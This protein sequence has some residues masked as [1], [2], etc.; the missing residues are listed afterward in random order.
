MNPTFLTI[1]RQ[2]RNGWERYLAG[3]SL[4]F[5]VYLIIAVP[6]II[7]S[8]YIEG[9]SIENTNLILYGNPLRSI[10]FQGLIGVALL[11]GL[12]LAVTLIHRRKF[13]TLFSVDT[14]IDWFRIIKGFILWLGLYGI[15]F[16]VRYLISPSRYSLTFNISEWLPFTLLVL[17][18][19][20]ILSL[21]VCLLYAYMLQ[22]LGLLIRHPLLLS[23]VWGLILGSLAID[24][25]MPIYWIL[26]VAS[27]MFM[28]WIV[29]KDNRIELVI[30]INI[31]VSLISLLFISSS[32]SLI[33]APTIFKVADFSDFL[34]VFVSYV[35]RAGFF[36]FICFGRRRNLS[37]ST[38]DD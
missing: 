14:A 19:V 12:F 25:K 21:A 23:I 13:M 34:P 32:D 16:S 4:V 17:I 11:L 2:G 1:A 38:I 37:E 8:A 35:L 33:K 28:T 24:L 26:S 7:I 9:I 10:L 20:P 22:A 27:S 29:I 3:I 31:A 15:S 6:V 36:Y 18:F 30:G 5:S